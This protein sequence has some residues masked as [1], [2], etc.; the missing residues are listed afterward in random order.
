MYKIKTS[1]PDT[2]TKQKPNPW[3][4]LVNKEYLIDKVLLIAH[5]LG[6]FVF[7]SVTI[8]Y[9]LFKHHFK[10]KIDQDWA[11]QMFCEPESR[12]KRVN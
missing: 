12:N 1:T 7:I 4:S 2:E 9:E 11:C 5:R 8:S 6:H 3:I 10:E